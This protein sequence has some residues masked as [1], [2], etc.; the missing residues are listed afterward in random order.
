MYEVRFIYRDYLPYTVLVEEPDIEDFFKSLS[1]NKPYFDKDKLI[2]F[3]LPP[4]SVRCA[5][6][7]KKVDACCQ[8]ME[9]HPCQEN[10][11]SEA[12]NALAI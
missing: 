4:E 5:Y 11:S 3:W 2:G 7:V 10:Q 12:D 6:V 1:S 9:N 8:S